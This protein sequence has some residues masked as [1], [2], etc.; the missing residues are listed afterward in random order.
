MIE[1]R[2]KEIMGD[3]NK[4]NSAI[5]YWVKKMRAESIVFGR[6]KIQKFLWYAQLLSYAR[7]RK[8]IFGD[9]E[10]L[11][12][13]YGPANNETW[14]KWREMLSPEFQKYSL[15]FDEM[16]ENRDTNEPWSNQDLKILNL[17]YKTKKD[18]G[19]WALAIETHEHEPYIKARMF[20]DIPR[21]I[22]MSFAEISVK[23]I[24]YIDI[25]KHADEI[26]DTYIDEDLSQK[27]CKKWYDGFA[28][29]VLANFWKKGEPL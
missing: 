9:L 10:F 23:K 28:K 20:S 18:L 27:Q 14:L 29:K 19:T 11:T 8:F 1:K 7:Y 3:I 17:V 22:A 16:L 26:V 12:F 25:K 6:F 13:R 5:V 2:K 21:E 4:A 15:R 24:K